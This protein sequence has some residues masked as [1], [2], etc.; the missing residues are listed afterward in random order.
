MNLR[1]DVKTS[2]LFKFTLATKN[3]NLIFFNEYKVFIFYTS[4]NQN[5]FNKRSLNHGIYC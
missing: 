5:Q 3:F 4:N 2:A 1:A